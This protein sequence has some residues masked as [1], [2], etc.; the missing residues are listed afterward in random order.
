MVLGQN[1]TRSK[2]ATVS[3]G[4]RVREVIMSNMHRMH[5]ARSATLAR[6]REARLAAAP[7]KV[8]KATEIRDDYRVRATKREREAQS[9]AHDLAAALG[10]IVGGKR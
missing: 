3:C 1:L 7:V 9:A 6:K 5:A 10:Y 8:A 4:C 2:G